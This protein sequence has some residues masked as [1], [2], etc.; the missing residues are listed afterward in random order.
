AMGRRSYSSYC[1]GLAAGNTNWQRLA[2]V[3]FGAFNP[4]GKLTMSF[5]RHVGQCPIY[6]N[7]YNTGRPTGGNGVFWSHYTDESN[8]PLYPFGFGLSYTQFAYDKLQVTVEAGKR[9]LVTVDVTNVGKR[10]GEEVSQLYLHDKVA[11]V[12]RPVKELKGFQKYSLEPGETQKL[13]FV[14][15]PEEL[16]YYNNQGEFV[17][18]AGSFS[19][20]VGT[21]SQQGLWADFE[22]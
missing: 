17:V 8:D 22:W 13:E 15:T 9:V 4:S 11:S 5:P 10:V 2:D 6:Y 18:E 14:L 20:M 16:G 3:L 7:R 1:G 12:A 21:N 19:V